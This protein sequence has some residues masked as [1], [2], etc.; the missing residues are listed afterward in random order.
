MYKAK[1]RNLQSSENNDSD[2][3]N[4]IDLSQIDNLI[5][6]ININTI[7]GGFPRI[8]ICDTEITKKILEKKPREFSHNKIM[9][10]KDMLKLKKKIEPSYSSLLNIT[11][12]TMNI[13]PGPESKI[14]GVSIDLI[15]GKSSLSG[16]QPSS[17]SGKSSLSGLQPSSLSGKSSLSGLQPSSLSG[18]SNSL[19][20]KKSKVSKKSFN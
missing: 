20:S 5:N 11:N 17:L 10:I 7:K 6:I 3:I 1:S 9:S 13:I 2:D 14:N 19:K 8:K 18:K 4:D 15:T 12:D 16:L